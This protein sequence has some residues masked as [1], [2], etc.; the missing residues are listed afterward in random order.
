[1]FHMKH[2]TYLILV[3]TTGIEPVDVTKGADLQS[4]VANQQLPRTQ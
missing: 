1:M 3:G 4:A 2:G